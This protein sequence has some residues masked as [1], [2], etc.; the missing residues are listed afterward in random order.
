M[1][2][3]LSF[4][5][6]SLLVCR[7]ESV[8]VLIGPSDEEYN[9]TNNSL[10]TSDQVILCPNLTVAVTLCKSNL[11][12]ELKF[13]FLSN[14]EGLEESL[15][16]E[17]MHSVYMTSNRHVKIYC[18][19]N[20][21]MFTGGRIGNTILSIVNIT[22]H[23]CGSNEVRGLEMV[24]IS[25][26]DLMLVCCEYMSSVSITNVANVTVYSSIFQHSS[27][28]PFAVL[29][30]AYN[31]STFATNSITLI[32]CFFRSN[33]EN[34]TGY[35]AVEGLAGI[36]AVAI[37]Q[38]HS[39]NFT[40]RMELC[41]FQENMIPL[42]S[43]QSPMF[44][45]SQSTNSVISVSIKHCQFIGNVGSLVMIVL[46]A[47][48][49]DMD[50]SIVLI[51]N[52]FSGNNN[53]STGDY[54][55]VHVLS[56][57]NINKSVTVVYNLLNFSRN[58][59]TLMYISALSGYS[60]H[61][62][63]NCSF[64]KNVQRTQTM[65]SFIGSSVT[66]Q[67]THVTLRNLI[68][69]S[70][71]VGTTDIPSNIHNRSIIF[72]KS[73]EMTAENLY[74]VGSN[75][76]TATMLS[77]DT[78]DAHFTGD[79]I[80]YY[81]RGTYGGGLA[82]R[83]SNVTIA[84]DSVLTF[85]NNYADYGGAVYVDAK[86]FVKT[87]NCSGK[88]NFTDNNY[89]RISGHSL[90]STAIDINYDFYLDC[91]NSME[92]MSTA[93][94]PAESTIF[95]SE[96]N[97]L[98]PG[99]VIKFNVTLLDGLGHSASCK[100]QVSLQ[101]QGVL[102][103]RMD[104]GL[105][106]LGPP[107]VFLQGRNQEV[108]TLLYIR[109][110][111]NHTNKKIQLLTTCIDPYMESKL[112]KIHVNIT[113][114]PF[115][116]GNMEKSKTCNCLVNKCVEDYGIACIKKGSW[117]NKDASI[118][119]ECPYPLCDIRQD[120]N[121]SNICKLYYGQYMVALPLKI[122]QQCAFNRG[123]K[124]C[125]ECQD[126]YH[127]TFGGV[128]CTNNC[129]SF[130]P[131]IILLLAVAFQFMIV[132]FILVAIRLKL[133][134]GSGFMYG[135]LLFLAIIGQLPFGYYSQFSALKIIV[136]TFTSL[137]LVNLEIFG[138]IPWCFGNEPLMV[139]FIFYYLG[140]ILV[141][142]M[143]LLL[144]AAGR[145]CPRILSK[146]QDSPIQA[147]CVLTMLSFWSV[148]N[149]SIHLLIPVNVNGHYYAEI[150]P[151][152]KY[153]HGGH[154]AV[155]LFAIAA[156]VLVLLFISLLAVSNFKVFY[157]IFRF[158]RFKPLL[159]ELKSCYQDKCRWYC[160]IYYI[161]WIFYLILYRFQLGPP[162]LLLLLLSLHFIFQPYR[163]HILNVIDMFLML[164]LLFLSS[165]LNDQEHLVDNDP[166][167]TMLVHVMA[168][169][170]LIY[171][172]FGCV[173]IFVIQCYRRYRLRSSKIVNNTIQSTKPVFPSQDDDEREPLIRILQNE[174]D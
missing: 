135:P 153:F 136:S 46:E 23:R 40:F 145:C 70:G 30:I 13:I 10:T 101:C 60:N 118:I 36:L 154:I 89:A 5:L 71:F 171:V 19:G 130:Y 100:A 102:C 74:L 129:K 59:G 12:Q 90:Y 163:T 123:G 126:N 159:D 146:I 138:E 35:S 99:Q 28:N 109:V 168:L 166:F 39:R 158:H 92:G 131:V 93:P 6:L 41:Q 48:L 103:E 66:P 91:F 160:V 148:A 32:G 96:S 157:H 38:V 82:V 17:V 62:V 14:Y 173:G 47:L 122:N 25:R 44:F 54:G 117:V 156:L 80:F 1:D 174:S 144:V 68:N 164:D 43:L 152:I 108:N 29:Q 20:S 170:P 140:P 116:F 151:N 63:T 24:G 125:S 97:Q 52:S 165:L 83:G 150:D 81:N 172:M 139:L 133:E 111:Q 2:V 58:Y 110:S 141:W 78:V 85:S 22:F 134:I 143:L 84:V 73:L 75:T 119:M 132:L 33:N 155:V 4:I 107:D 137:F 124:R 11:T 114:C 31:Q 120:N 69:V 76:S 106:L 64:S 94:V 149:T 115:G 42:Y 87:W 49:D 65:L 7:L 61:V 3:Y 57:N 16:C 56:N 121:R 127:F 37:V 34:D 55:L 88:V 95:I 15:I 162:I 147:I 79:N 105:E 8:N 21:L 77:L 45:I 128:H 9:C 50:T 26:V 72:L 112:W 53:P 104:T 113:Q 98:Y 167:F 18:Y 142:A 86:S 51:N 169:L 27:T 67:Y 161:F